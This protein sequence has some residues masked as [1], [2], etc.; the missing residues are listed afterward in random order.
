MRNAI[1]YVNKSKDHLLMVKIGV[2]GKTFYGLDCFTPIKVEESDIIEKYP[3]QIGFELINPNGRK[4]K[5]VAVQMIDFFLRDSINLQYKWKVEYL[6]GD[7]GQ[8]S[9]E[10]CELEKWKSNQKMNLKEFVE[11]LQL[12]VSDHGDKEVLME[13]SKY[14]TGISD[15]LVKNEFVYISRTR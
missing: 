13:I 1:I 4:V 15:V 5:L 3:R 9:I 11:K 12:M 6:D 10:D 14:D 2:N 8:D 7:P